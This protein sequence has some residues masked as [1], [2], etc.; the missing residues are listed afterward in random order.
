MS[1][2]QSEKNVLKNSI[3]CFI[4]DIQIDRQINNYPNTVRRPL[5]ILFIP[6]TH[7]DC[8]CCE[9]FNRRRVDHHSF[10]VIV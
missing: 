4:P 3:Q 7:A 9:S 10:Y 2:V 1:A 6:I 5:G 8:G